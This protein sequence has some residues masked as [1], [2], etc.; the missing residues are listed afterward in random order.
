MTAEPTLVLAGKPVLEFQPA[1]DFATGR[2][3]GFEALVR[4]DHPTKGHI[5]PE[6]LLPWAEANDDIVSLNSWVISE[7]CAQAQRW[8]SGIQ[9]AVNCSIVQ[10]RRGEASGAVIHALEVS[11]LNPDRLTIEVTERAIADE[12]ASQDLRAVSGLGV[13]LAVDDVGTSWSTLEPLRRFEVETVKID[14]AFITSLEAREGMNRAI[15]EAV[16]HVSHTLAMSTV[17][18]GVESAQQVA[19][20]REFGADV[21]QG[22]FF[23]PP[24]SDS[25]T[26][27]LA[28]VE[29]RAVYPLGAPRTAGASNP[30]GVARTSTVPLKVITGEGRADDVHPAGGSGEG[31]TGAHP[32]A[33]AISRA[34]RDH[35][36]AAQAKPTTSLGPD[37]G[38]GR[39]SDEEHDAEQEAEEKTSSPARP[40]AKASPS[41]RAGRGSQSGTG[42]GASPAGS[43]RA[44]K[45]KGGQ[46]R[47]SGGGRASKGQSNPPR[48]GQSTPP[49]PGH[50][51]AAEAG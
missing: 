16:I 15:V 24:L 23:D 5:P 27:S 25:A 44:S 7:A 43:Q 8:P 47:R 48:R 17:A 12:N 11:G 3:L 13:H 45:A 9:V 30:R 40:A 38:S 20:L 28:N 32:D 6:V 34:A 37:V 10:L 51:N 36:S 2:L 42:R 35:P 26:H 1:V 19:I 49:K 41:A 46:R 39:D 18:E 21:G 33:E 50:G 4:W 22:Y 14:K 29:P 31:G